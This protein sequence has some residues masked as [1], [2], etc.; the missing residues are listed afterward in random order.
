MGCAPLTLNPYTKG[1][2]T[3]SSFLQAPRD[4]GSTNYKHVEV[5]EGV[6]KLGLPLGN[7]ALEAQNWKH[8]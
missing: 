1:F 6:D 2:G 3:L 5:H 7:C 4:H 8:C